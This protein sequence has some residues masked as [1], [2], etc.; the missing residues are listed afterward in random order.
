VLDANLCT[1]VTNG[2]KGESPED[3]AETECL[4]SVLG[5]RLAGRRGRWSIFQGRLDL[6]LRAEPRAMCLHLQAVGDG[7][8]GE[9]AGL[10]AIPDVCSCG[11]RICWRSTSTRI[12]SHRSL[13]GVK[14]WNSG[15]CRVG[16][17]PIRVPQEG[18]EPGSLGGMPG[19]L[20]GG[21]LPAQC[22]CGDTAFA[23]EPGPPEEQP[24]LQR[25]GV[26]GRVCIDA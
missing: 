7:E 16:G 8:W 24:P 19:R 23:N 10:D 12:L 21:A 13:V 22:K 6:E 9:V 14:A 11:W 1:A 26:R 17:R 25:L 2:S 18:E 5:I 4:T 20:I 15:R 3:L